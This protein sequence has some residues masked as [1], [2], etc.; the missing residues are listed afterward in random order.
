MFYGIDGEIFCRLF[1]VWCVCK[2]LQM[3]GSYFESRERLSMRM[4]IRGVTIQL[5]GSGNLLII[6]FGKK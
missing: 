3:F 1:Y 6:C 5:S 2:C 4:R